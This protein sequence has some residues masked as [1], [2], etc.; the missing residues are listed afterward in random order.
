MR[1]LTSLILVVFT[2]F[3][4]CVN[5]G[6]VNTELP[7][8]PDYYHTTL[9]YPNTRSTSLPTE[10]MSM[11]SESKVYD[12]SI[13]ELGNKWLYT[14]KYF[15][16]TDFLCA[17]F[18]IDYNPGNDFVIA[19]YDMTSKTWVKEQTFEMPYSVYP[20]EHLGGYFSTPQLNTSHHYVIAFKEV[21]GSHTASLSGSC[22][23]ANNFDILG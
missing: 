5:A 13:E 22:M 15:Y 4:L 8:N 23:I 3:S 1:K 11:K 20:P 9:R 7:Q 14:N 18:L 2:L 21:N 10:G 17:S 16:D 6:A 12:A 19:C